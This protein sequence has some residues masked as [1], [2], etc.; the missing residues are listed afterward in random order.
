MDISAVSTVINTSAQ[1]R[2]SSELASTGSIEEHNDTGSIRREQ[3]H[4]EHRQH[5][6]LGAFRQE[7]R[8]NL[9][10]EFHAKFS[11]QQKGY[12]SL[13]GPPT[14][15]EVAADALQTAK[16]LTAES[17]A[18]AS[19]SLI[20]LKAT[21]HE[22]ARYVLETVSDQ[23]DFS[24]VDDAVAK[25]DAGIAELEQEVARSRESSASVL[26]ID[27][28]TKQR[29]TIRIRTQEGDI[30]KLSLRRVDQFSATDR[31]ESDGES[32]ATYTEVSISSR[33]R[34]M[35]KVEGDLNAAELEAI[36][37]VFA[38][39]EQIANDF[40]A[41]DLA[42][43]FAS[44]EGF[45]FDTEQLAR[46]NMRF[47]MQ[48]QTE[49]SYRIETRSAA[50][51]VAVA[52]EPAPAA[53]VDAGPVAATETAAVQPE[54]VAPTPKSVV[55]AET[56]ELAPDTSALGRFLESVGN[57]LRGIGDGFSQESGEASF[58]LHYSESFKLELLKAVIH[59]TAPEDS[60][61]A[62]NNAEAVLEDLIEVS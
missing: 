35:L 60:S 18:T 56:A 42:A 29:S 8:F 46:V 52:A 6:A 5:R 49:A 54:P 53:V 28:R 57:F 4:R 23:D 21:V 55:P 16:Q 48:Q 45:E 12:A 26:E 62:A 44:T 39:A 37:N 3:H 30:V 59:T 20:H 1:L 13:Q 40:F 61:D 31:A 17:P 22:A 27:T 25:V 36:E 38:Q 34:M 33:S 15:D 43:A 32:T 10:L 47:R 19:K 11:V 9:K 14:P 51:P 50:S 7:M 41:G 58:R 24:E 2:S